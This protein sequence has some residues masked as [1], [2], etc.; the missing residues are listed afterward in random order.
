MTTAVFQSF[1]TF[2]VYTVPMDE[3]NI[4]ELIFLIL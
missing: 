3:G 1:P 2:Q 4:A